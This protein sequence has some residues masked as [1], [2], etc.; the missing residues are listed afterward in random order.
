MRTRTVLL[1]LLVASC[2]NTQQ[3]PVEKGLLQE[4]PTPTAK[5]T[6]AHPAGAGKPIAVPL[7]LIAASNQQIPIEQTS[8]PFS[9]TASDGSGLRVTRVEAK[10]VV[11]GPV[12]FTELHLY[13]QNTENR[14]REGQFA[15]TLPPGAAVS[16]FAMENDGT[17]MEAEVVEKQLARRAYDDFLHRKQDPALMEKG[18]GNQFTAKVFPIPANG[19][20]HLV[21]SF[22][23]ELPGQRYTLPLRG[24]PKVD[25]VDV[26]LETMDMQGVKGSQ[27]L[28]KRDW[29][30]DSDF[31]S[32]AP[33]SAEA[34][35]S[36]QFVV[37]QLSPFDQA[38]VAKDVPAAVTVLVDTS[39]SRALGFASYANRIKDLL[40]SM[41]QAYP[42]VNVDVV[43]FDQDSKSIYSGPAAGFGTAQ[44]QALVARGAAGASDLSQALAGIAQPQKR[45]VVITDGVITAGKEGG[46]LAASIK[47]LG[48]KGVERVDVA[49]AGGIRDEALATQLVTSGL[50]RTGAV[51]DLDASVRDVAQGIGER[52]MTDIDVSVE[53]AAWVYPSV[54]KS[55]RPGQ[56]TMVFAKMKA[57]AKSVVVKIGSTRRDVATIAGTSA[58]VER[59]VASAEITDL[60]NTLSA[61]TKPDEKKALQKQIADKS[62]AARV[63]SSQTSMLV[64]ENNS[65]YAR[66][67]IDRNALA[68]ILVIGPNGLEQK[69]RKGQIATTTP[70]KT[71][72]VAQKQQLANADKAK[73]KE[74]GA[75]ETKTLDRKS[76]EEP[77][78]NES[79]DESARRGVKDDEETEQKPP[80][81]MTKREADL[82]EADGVA[83]GPSGGEG[84]GVEAGKVSAVAAN[85]PAPA[86]TAAP[87]APPPPPGAEPMARM[88]DVGRSFD[89]VATGVTTSDNYYV[90]TP[91]EQ[92]PPANSPAA[93]KGQL[94]TIMRAVKGGKIDQGLALAKAWHE[95]DPGDVLALIGYGEAL[96]ANKNL[97][98]AARIYGSIIDLFPARA[99][100]RRFAGERLE[101]I[102]AASR[103]LAVDTYRRAVEE[104]PDHLTGHRLLAYALL[105]NNDLPGA[106]DAI[107]AGVDRQYPEGQYLGGDRVL[108]EDVGMIAGA[109]LAAAPDKKKEIVAQLNKRGIGLPK[110]ASTRFI[111]YWETDAN[112]V[113]FHIQ[114]S[115]G[116]HAWYSSKE[117]P[118][119]GELYA[120]ITTGYGPECFAIQGRPTAGPYKLSI[121][122]YSMGPMGYG[123]GLLQ[124]VNYD[125]KGGLKFQD[126][127]YVIMNDHAYVDLGT[128]KP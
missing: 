127:P 19:V 96:E 28:Q 101:R 15:I 75:S 80:P 66:Y 76:L 79:G 49:L 61:A 116:G 56:R 47:A 54:I 104:R 44:V 89:S 58:L 99:D 17:F 115:K 36:G 83:M 97:E 93:L 125:G 20:K 27:L 70:A 33:A 113:D 91:P 68:D 62:I 108:K 123:M 77:E 71:P 72:V 65:D 6:E 25:R 57:P 92:F 51:M 34:I 3:A 8:A 128:Y 4:A 2:S 121:N 90:N 81:K 106:F 94:A 14:V 30:P 63:I 1:G 88:P 67:G 95:K 85:D 105:R 35:A 126:R 39:A 46:E 87:P 59:A 120:D 10:A 122:Y 48:I 16:R 12:A 117:L 5:V 9:L 11:Q 45:I 103:A 107:L 114:D 78:K 109:Y 82:D 64:L 53:G 60:E 43:A 100:L 23:Q 124:I 74:S 21:L 69:N 40:G 29:Q 118:S 13:F 7:P 22:S 102:G 119:G 110:G 84:G 52:V 111:M 73:G 24:L 98:Q 42:G 31:T 55:A 18:E 26:A 37:A 50:V 41:A 112:D 86:T 32:T 38:T